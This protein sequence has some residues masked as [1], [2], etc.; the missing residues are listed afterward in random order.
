ML[1]LA[2]LHADIVPLAHAVFGWRGAKERRAFLS[3]AFPRMY[4]DN[5]AN[6]RLQPWLPKGTPSVAPKL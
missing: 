5:H 1:K 6:A 2:V 3:K 4:K